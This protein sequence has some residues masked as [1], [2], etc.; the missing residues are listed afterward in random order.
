MELREMGK[1]VAR[2]G[3]LSPGVAFPDTDA[4]SH[5]ALRGL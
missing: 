1:D 2:V 4:P 5:W 3:T